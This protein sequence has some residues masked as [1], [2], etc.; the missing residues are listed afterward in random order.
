MRLETVV[1]PTS[2]LYRY[3][4]MVDVLRLSVAEN[5]PATGL[6]VRCPENADREVFSVA[7]HKCNRVWIENCRKAKHHA[8]IIRESEPGELLCMIDADTMVLRPLDSLEQSGFDIAYTTRPAGSQWRLNSGVYFVRVSEA[9]RAFCDQWEQVCLT[10]LADEQLH[11]EWRVQ[12]AYGGI[13]QAGV[14]LYAPAQ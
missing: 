11:H 7:R 6:T 13:H 5:S 8:Q 3:R 1:F 10:M 4:R 2:K 14:R 12:H 9:T